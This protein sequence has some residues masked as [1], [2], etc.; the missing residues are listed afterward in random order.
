VRFPPAG[1]PPGFLSTAAVSFNDGSGPALYV[2]GVHTIGDYVRKWDGAA[3][4]D[5]GLGQLNRIVLDA[6]VHDDGNGPALY[7]AFETS[8]FPGSPGGA[9]TTGSSAGVA[10]WDVATSTWV[11]LIDFRTNEGIPCTGCPQAGVGAR[12]VLAIASYDNGTGAKL[13]AVGEFDAKFVVWNGAAWDPVLPNPIFGELEGLAVFNDGTGDALYVGDS[14]GNV[15]KWSG[16]MFGSPVT[17]FIGNSFA[18]HD[19]GSG[20]ALYGVRRQ[21]AGQNTMRVFRWDGTT[22]SQVG[23]TFNGPVYAL[24]SHNDGSGSRLYVYGGFTEASGLPA[25]NAAV[26]DGGAWAPLGFGVGGPTSSSVESLA[27]FNDGSGAGPALFVGGEFSTID[28]VAAQG[29]ARW[30]GSSFASIGGVTG[31][32]I[33]LQP[34]TDGAGPSIYVGGA[35]GAA[36]GVPAQNLA[37]WDGASWSEVGGGV[38]GLQVIAM[39]VH[40]DGSGPA[41]YIGGVFSGVGGVAASNVARWDGASWSTLGGGVQGAVFSLA[42]YNGDLYVGGPITSAGGVPINGGVARW[43]GSSWSTVGG[44]MNGAVLGMTVHDDGF[45]PALFVGGTFTSIGGAPANRVARWNGAA[46]SALGH[47]TVTPGG[48]ANAWVWALRSFNDGSGPAL[49]IAGDFTTVTG[50]AVDSLRGGDD[51]GVRSTVVV[52]RLAR[53]RNGQWSA[54][55]TGFDSS[56]RALAAFDDGSGDPLSLIA[57]GDFSAAGGVPSPRLSRW[58]GCVLPCPG[59]LT[60]SGSVGFDDLNLI[61]SN[62]GQTVNPPGTG[63]D[64]NGDGVV[65][66]NDMNAVLAAF[67]M[68]CP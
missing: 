58:R 35:F 52:N 45:G 41:L 29:V 24:A 64:V 54:L 17:G 39:T 32:V 19:D 27:T 26:W 67:G 43:N 37:R 48:G 10:R 56:V 15:F 20:S 31:S 28:G 47:A 66:F 59:D 55:G 4:S 65:D 61:L 12:R 8:E 13:Y 18:V 3:W 11:P 6:T 68:P 49:Y 16:G 34:F 42:S 44:S 30:D 25:S 60:G 63:G 2:A 57:G 21:D 51:A 36:G 62:F 40:N 23:E 46:W 53:W 33:A 9:P 5:V 50:G 14:D 38:Q 7:V 1:G 22:A